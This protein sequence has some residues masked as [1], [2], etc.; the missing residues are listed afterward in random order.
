M[1]S[2]KMFSFY[3][4]NHKLNKGIFSSRSIKRRRGKKGCGDNGDDIY[5]SADLNGDT[6]RKHG[7][8]MLSYLLLF[9]FFQYSTCLCS[10][11]Q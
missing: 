9:L 7:G 10:A 5:E 3:Q 11:K 2:Q 8:V 4:N 6:A 1:S